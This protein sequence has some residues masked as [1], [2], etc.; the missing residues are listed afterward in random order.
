MYYSKKEYKFIKFEKSDRLG[1]KY[2]AIIEN[3]KTK[4]RVKIPFGSAAYQQYKDKTVL[5]L[6]KHLNH[7]D[8]NRR[9]LYKSRHMVFIKPGY[10]SAGQMSMDFLW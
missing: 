4:K 10:Y 1:K 3:K 8:K 5:N 9:R 6:Y 2:N 7:N